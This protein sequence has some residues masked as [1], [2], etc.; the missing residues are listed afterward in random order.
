[1]ATGEPRHGGRSQS[2]REGEG[3]GARRAIGR[4]GDLRP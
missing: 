1:M 2:E 4:D 3:V